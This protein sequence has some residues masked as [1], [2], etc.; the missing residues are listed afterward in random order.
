[1]VRV[2]PA[3]A[4]PKGRVAAPGLL[5]LG[6]PGGKT[7][8]HGMG[9]ADV[10]ELGDAE[11]V[12]QRQAAHVDG[13]VAHH[14]LH[15][16][17]R[18]ARLVALAAEVRRTAEVRE[19]AEVLL[20]SVLQVL[21]AAH[22]V[23]TTARLHQALENDV[24]VV[25]QRVLL[26][27]PAGGEVGAVG[28]V[29]V[30]AALVLHP[31]ALR[32]DLLHLH[33]GALLD[34]AFV[35]EL[36]VVVR[37]VALLLAER[38]GVAVVQAVR[39]LPRVALFAKRGIYAS[40]PAPTPTLGA[41]RM[42]A[43]AA[44]PRAADQA[45]VAE[46]LAAH[47]VVQVRL[48][49]DVE[50]G[51]VLR[52]RVVGEHRLRN[53]LALP[54]RPLDL[55]EHVLRL[56]ARRL[57]EL[58]RHDR[59][60]LQGG[61]QDLVP[62]RH[63]LARQLLLN[64]LLPHRHE[65]LDVRRL[66]LLVLRR[67][68]VLQPLQNRLARVLSVD[69]LPE[70]RV[71][72]VQLR[73]RLRRHEARLAEQRRRGALVVR[74]HARLLLQQLV[75][76]ALAEDAGALL[77][78]LVLQEGRVRALLQQS[79]HHIRGNVLPAY[80]SA[81]RHA[82]T[83]VRH[84]RL[85]QAQLQTRALEHR[86]LV[87]PARDEAIH[88]HRLR[89]PNPVAARLRL[90]V[91]LRVPV[92][93]ED[94]HRVGRGERDAHAACARAQ[95]KAEHVAVLVVERADRLLAGIASDRA[96][97]PRVGVASEAQIA[98]QQVQHRRELAEDQNAVAFR[99]QLAQQLMQQHHLPARLDQRVLR[100]VLELHP[101]RLL[102][103]FALH[104]LDSLQHVRVVAALPELHLHAHQ[105]GAAAVP[106][107]PRHA[108]PRP[109][110]PVDEEVPIVVVDRAVERL[111]LRGQL[112]VDDRLL[113]RRNGVLHV[114]L[115]A[116]QHVRYE[117][118]LQRGH[119]RLVVQIAVLLQELGGRGERLRG[120][121]VQQGP[122]LEHVVLQRGACEQHALLPVDLVQGLLQLARL[123]LHP[124]R[125]VDDHQTPPNLSITPQEQANVLQLIHVGV[126]DFVRCE[127]NVELVHRERRRHR[128]LLA[129]V[130]KLIA[131][132]EVANILAALVVVIHY[133]IQRR[134]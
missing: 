18:V 69:L 97:D 120:H 121:E 9:I 73:V 118:S 64:R 128:Q 119:L 53:M 127:K 84:H 133:H 106:R 117:Q 72:D 10:V 60:L 75:D 47:L 74:H 61:V 39:A 14:A 87:R 80:A 8:R 129:R 111:L 81:R 41:L 94:D 59:H 13:L 86:R 101:L 92:G 27:L 63:V 122:Q 37:V 1:M 109:D 4:G 98:L 82:P 16:M 108:V 93:V 7:L 62:L 126:R 68:P 115:H 77:A 30:V 15:Q 56:R 23:E 3:A 100:Q 35:H 40:R 124:L 50:V 114:L 5:L 24:R 48:A 36:L 49:V 103:L 90:H 91:V 26:L 95:Q 89:L 132:N 67:A 32:P 104:F 55:L 44:R 113:L 46:A 33:V 102:Q 76:V 20:A 79:L 17:L 66:R 112:H 123:V 107:H 99:L 22:V 45:V 51:V 134:P 78:L 52:V 130:I 70:Q 65:L 43:A 2:V 29:V 131:L 6:V 110:V 125:L 83:A 34:L 38:A 88:A 31:A 12:L 42:E 11:A 105:P 25:R 19:V 96:I 71:V 21:D 57:A 58:L 54:T 28:V 116:A 85:L